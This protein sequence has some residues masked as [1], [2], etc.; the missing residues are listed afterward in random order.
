MVPACGRHVGSPRAIVHPAFDP[1]KGWPRTVRLVTSPALTPPAPT[2]AIGDE[3]V[4]TVERWAARRRAELSRLSLAVRSARMKA[5]QAERAAI[6]DAAAP[7]EVLSVVEAVLDEAVRDGDQSLAEARRAAAALV[8]AEYERASSDLRDLGLDPVASLGPAGWGPD[9][10]WEVAGPASADD[11]WQA[12]EVEPRVPVLRAPDAPP[13]LLET[14][15]VGARAEAGAVPAPPGGLAVEVVADGRGAERDDVEGPVPVE[16]TPSWY[17]APEG[18][19]VVA[20]VAGGLHGPEWREWRGAQPASR[21]RGHRVPAGAARSAHSAVSEPTAAAVAWPED[22]ESLPVLA[23]PSRWPD[24]AQAA[25]EFPDAPEVDA[26]SDPTSPDPDAVVPSADA[27]RFD[28]FMRGPG[29]F[30]VFWG[31]VEDRQPLRDRLRR[32]TAAEEPR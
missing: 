23:F 9:P 32:R 19:T 13:R 29:T 2:W 1:A 17:L 20:E 5:E 30:D 3:D 16:P 24:A 27:E 4:A 28:D 25:R 6:L 18:V 10:T 8:A 15:D 14:D 31:D 7:D 22:D 21:Q 11:L 26:V 12:L